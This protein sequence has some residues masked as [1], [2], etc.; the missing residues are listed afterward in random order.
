MNSVKGPSARSGVERK[1]GK[2]GLPLLRI[3]NEFAECDIYLYGAHVAR[4]IPEGEADLLWVSPTSAFREGVPIRGGI[5]ICFPWF[6]PH[7]VRSDLPLHGFVRDCL[8]SLEEAGRLDDGRTLAVLGCEDTARTR[9]IWPHRFRLEMRIRVGR[10]LCLTQFAENTGE[11]PFRYEDCLH[12]YFRVGDSR[13]CEIQGLDGVSYIDRTRGDARA[14]QQGSL[15]LESETINAY[16]NAP[17]RCE[18]RDPRLGRVILVEQE[19]FASTVA[20]NPGEAAAAKNPEIGGAWNQYICLESANCLDT[21]V[22]LLPG[23]AH[24]S[25]LR[26]SLK[27]KGS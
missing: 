2:G 20:W 8:W 18:L 25:R 26:I 7:P 1:T 15:R 11:D 6:G 13:A 19:G 12:T 16:M 27:P 17:S 3:R 5:P 4:F 23:N 24:Q 22:L 9:E 21:P 14:V 10:D